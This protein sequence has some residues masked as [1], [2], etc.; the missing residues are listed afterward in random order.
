MLIL[1]NDREISDSIDKVSDSS[2]ILGTILKGV[3]HI[4]ELMVRV[5]DSMSDQIETNKTVNSEAVSV[6]Q[7]SHEIRGATDEQKN[8]ADEVVQSI[9][10]IN[11]LTQTNASA[12][13]EMASTTEEISA[14]SDSLK[15]KIGFFKI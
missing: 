11:E 3:T 15:E 14:M 13:E 1:V 9:Q 7:L 10:K 5:S 6:E 2:R 8:A 4:S 12:A